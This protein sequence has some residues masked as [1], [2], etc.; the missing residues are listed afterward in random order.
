[1]NNVPSPAR[2]NSRASAWSSGTGY[3]APGTAKG[4][5][6]VN[7][8]QALPKASGGSN[9]NKGRFKGGN[10]VIHDKQ[11]IPNIGKGSTEPSR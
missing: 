11:P 7:L 10:P 6:G 3:S 9:L 5:G 4:A 1:M 8:K 2:N